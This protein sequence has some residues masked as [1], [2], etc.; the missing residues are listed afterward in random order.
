MEAES[1]TGLCHQEEDGD[2]FLML[3]TGTKQ[4]ACKLLKFGL[5]T[6]TH[7]ADY[8]PACSSPGHVSTRG[9]HSSMQELQRSPRRCGS[10]RAPL[11]PRLARGRAG[12]Q[13]EASLGAPARCCLPDKLQSAR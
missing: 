13:A 10:W 9:F 7:P 12:L 8:A 4:N 2:P 1:A 3:D 6:S 5:F 11:G